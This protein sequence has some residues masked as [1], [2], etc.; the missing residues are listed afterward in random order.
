MHHPGNGIL[1]SFSLPISTAG[2]SLQQTNQSSYPEYAVLP[3]SSEIRFFPVDFHLFSVA[4]DSALSFA[5]QELILKKLPTYDSSR[6]AKLLTYLHHFIY[7]TFKLFRIQQEGWTID[8]L[9]TYKPPQRMVAIYN[10]N[11][12]ETGYTQKKAEEYLAEAIG[13]RARQTEVIIDRDEDDTAVI[14]EIVPDGVGNLR[15]VISNDCLIKAVR[16]SFNKLPWQERQVL[17]A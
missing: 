13:L 3:E 7:D 5:L 14:E 16:A 1:W 4:E 11:C 2:S 17:Q 15:H 12:Q 9:D 6:D 10:A 8:S